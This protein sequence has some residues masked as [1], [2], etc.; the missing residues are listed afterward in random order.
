MTSADQ[1]APVVPL[2][3]VV[4]EGVEPGG[5]APSDLSLTFDVLD[6]VERLQELG[7][8]LMR[9]LEDESGLRRSEFMVLRAIAGGESHPRRIG[10][11]VGL[12]TEAAVATAHSLAASGLVVIQH[13]GGAPAALELT[14]DGRAVLTQ[15]EAVQI[16]VTDAALA[17]IGPENAARALS[18]LDTMIDSMAPFAAQRVLEVSARPATA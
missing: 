7:E 5:A 18:V 16:R 4:G 10:R 2:L 3:A 6:R 9:T 15:A 8:S 1:C 14:D 13:D 11:A 12:A 17:H